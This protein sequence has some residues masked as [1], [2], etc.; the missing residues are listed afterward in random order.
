MDKEVI[1]PVAWIERYA[2]GG[3]AY[4]K[5]SDAVFDLPEGVRIELYPYQHMPRDVLVKALDDMMY[6]CACEWSNSDPDKM[7]E[8]C[9]DDIERIADRYASN[10]QP[11]GNCKFPLCQNEQYQ[12]DMA[13]ALHRELYAGQPEPVNQ[14]LL[15]ALK[16]CEARLALLVAAGRDKLLDAV[17]AEKARAA[18]AAAEEAHPAGMTDDVAVL[19]DVLLQN[20]WE[21]GNPSYLGE[22][23]DGSGK[24]QFVSSGLSGI[25][26]AQMDGLYRLAGINPRKIIPLGSCSECANSKAGRECGYVKPC[27]DC[28]RPR[29]SNFSPMLSAAKKPDGV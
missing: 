1:R 20:Q 18:I 28:K 19:R 11:D 13:E 8:L 4:D 3:V 29:M 21:D 24:W 2:G 7:V 23:G 16:H 15:A 14:Q 12:N 10:V 9:H 25:T 27:I 22:S 6:H 17:A 5:Y 26:P